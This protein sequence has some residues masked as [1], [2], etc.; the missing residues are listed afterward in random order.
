MFWMNYEGFGKLGRRSKNVLSHYREG[1]YG[2]GNGDQWT[3]SQKGG[4]RVEGHGHPRV[5]APAQCNPIMPIMRF[6]AWELGRIDRL[7]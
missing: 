7:C 3:L 5:Y 1:D 4:F 6:R 2:R